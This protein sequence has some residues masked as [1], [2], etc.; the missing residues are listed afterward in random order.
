M[1]ARKIIAIIFLLTQH[2]SI[3]CQLKA[4]VKENLFF[5]L[6]NTTNQE[7][8]ISILYKLALSSHKEK[9]AMA[10]KY[11]HKAI[12]IDHNTNN[13]NQGCLT[14][15]YNLL[16]EILYSQNNISE[17]LICFKNSIDLCTNFGLNIIVKAQ[18]LERIA[19]IQS[20]LGKTKEAKATINEAI[21]IFTN[22]NKNIFL[23]RCY[24]ILGNNYHQCK[25][26]KNAILAYR[27][28][29]SLDSISISLINIA[30]CYTSYM[31]KDSVLKYL[32]LCDKKV[33]TSSSS[34]IYTLYLDTY[35]YFFYTQGQ[36]E[37]AISYLQKSIDIA[38]NE[39]LD[40][41][42][43]YSSKLL[44]NC[45]EQT[46]NNTEAFSYYKQYNTIKEKSLTI[47][48]Y[49]AL[50]VLNNKKENP[51]TYIFT[52]L[53]I[54]FFIFS[55]I[56][57]LIITLICNKKEL[58]LL[59]KTEIINK[60]LDK[61]IE[62]RKQEDLKFSMELQEKEKLLYEIQ[63]RI[64]SI[65]KQSKINRADISNLSRYIKEKNQNK[66]VNLCLKKELLDQNFYFNLNEK[67]SKLST[68]EKKLA[69]Y[70]RLNY[71][72]KEIANTLNISSRS[73]NMNRYRL[74]KKL[75]LKQEDKLDEFL[76][77]I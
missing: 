20:S 54:L 45:Y 41:R 55:V 12:D 65:S 39:G 60:L 73:V 8:K 63:E 69:L 58:K 34:D 70:I 50:S 56:E 23:A 51:N 67:Y 33:N 21:N 35:G 4:E 11:L 32:E 49:K 66:R 2:T 19:S 74:R 7:D 43:M 30:S 47:N 77:S 52:F 10:I 71:S 53:L 59:Y 75:N 5:E 57:F 68:N 27:K 72:S 26:Y 38:K 14:K 44:S 18:C 6:I 15:V 61:K 17:S 13:N 48:N 9:P 24:N 16:G 25:D 36:Y 42:I 76:K 46:H 37:K 22:N 64:R 3:Y 40:Y 31:K 29:Y 28:S 62:F 1:S